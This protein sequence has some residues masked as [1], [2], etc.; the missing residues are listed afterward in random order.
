MSTKLMSGK[1]SVAFLFGASGEFN[2][3]I[4]RTSEFVFQMRFQLQSTSH[5]TASC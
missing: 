1:S 2:C 3:V 4:L 5:V